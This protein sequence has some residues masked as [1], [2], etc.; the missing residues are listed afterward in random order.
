MAISTQFIM[1]NGAVDGTSNLNNLLSEN[2]QQALRLIMPRDLEKVFGP[3]LEDHY[4]YNSGY[5]DPEWYFRS[6]DGCV[7]GIGWRW[8]VARL[9]G[10][11][12]ASRGNM[13]YSRPPV[14]SA[15]E[16]LEFLMKSLDQS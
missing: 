3:G 13:F 2:S 15:H 4:D 11:G 10:R 16:F 12:A 6:S 7:W 5:T 8:G 9:R 14:D 1:D